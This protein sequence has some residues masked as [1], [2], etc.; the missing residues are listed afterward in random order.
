MH[1]QKKFYRYNNVVYEK[2]GKSGNGIKLNVMTVIHTTMVKQAEHLKK[3]IK[4]TLKQYVN[5]NHSKHANY[6]IN[7]SQSYLKL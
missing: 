3:D 6:L 5:Q 7:E 1:Q 2:Y 4:N